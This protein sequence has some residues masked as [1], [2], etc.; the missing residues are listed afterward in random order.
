MGA[1]GFLHHI[2]TFLLF[3]SAILLLI[4][5][6]SAPVIN[7]IGIM[8]VKLTNGTA[9]HHSVVSFGTFGYCVLDVDS[10]GNDYCT[11][12]HI[13]YNPAS[14]MSQIESTHFSHASED[15]SK[16]LT[17][18]M[19]LHPIACGIMFIAFLLALGAG[20]I[21]SF[22][23]ALV[24]SIAFIISV[25]AMA[26]DFVLFGIVKNHVNGDKSGS[27]AYFSVG[28]WCI[29]AAMIAGFL[30]AIVVFITCLSKR[31][32]KKRSRGV[33]EKGYVGGVKP[34]RRHFWQRRG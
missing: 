4:T 15:T 33:E 5:T 20:F 3:A 22:L 32:H 27:H 7:D 34:A 28:I 10:D 11:K 29:L 14:T 12:K 9:S 6:I 8:K 26:C 24:S 2:G 21:G 19:I 25:V 31:M 16:A 1:T 30:G 13:G 18:V 17:R 23:A